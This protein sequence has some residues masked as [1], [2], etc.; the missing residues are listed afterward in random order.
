MITHD[1]LFSTE[2]F[3]SLCARCL[4]KAHSLKLGTV[5]PVSLLAPLTSSLSQ[6]L[7]LISKGCRLPTIATFTVSSCLI[8]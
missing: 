7:S 5:I 4:T 1:N 8:V 2:N 6:I 3:D